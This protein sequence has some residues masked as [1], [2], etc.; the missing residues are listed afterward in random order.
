MIEC[1]EN[2]ESGEN[3][4]VDKHDFGE[5]TKWLIPVCHDEHWVLVMIDCEN[6]EVTLYD[7]KSMFETNDFYR[8]VLGS[9]LMCLE[10]RLEKKRDEC[11]NERAKRNF[12]RNFKRNFQPLFEINA[13][14]WKG[15][16]KNYAKC[17]EQRDVV[18]CGVYTA[19]A[20]LSKHFGRDPEDTVWIKKERR[21]G[22]PKE[23]VSHLLKLRH[24]IA[25]SILNNSFDNFEVR[26]RKIKD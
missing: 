16:P 25:H 22:H 8:H 4:H 19:L 2:L 6:R 23:L 24:G 21:H 17:A 20:L 14:K 3:E 15:I 13:W 7:G 10:S 1:F 9:L 12:E 26:E 18:S 5:V 11:K